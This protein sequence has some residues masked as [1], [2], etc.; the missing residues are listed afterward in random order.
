MLLKQFFSLGV[1]VAFSAQRRRRPKIH[2]R[3]L[4]TARIIPLT[5]GPIILLCYGERIYC[6]DDLVDWLT[7]ARSSSLSL[8]PLVRCT[9]LQLLSS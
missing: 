7:L 9:F 5:L 2:P 1:P 3:A 4:G 8:S 6:D